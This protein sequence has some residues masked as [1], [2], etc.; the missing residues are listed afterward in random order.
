MNDREL[1]ELVHAERDALADDLAGLDDA[2]WRTP[3]LCGDWTV[4]ETLAHL[5]AVATLGTPAWLRSVVGVRWDFDRHN[6]L[7]MREQ[8]GAGP[9]ETLARFRA[10]AHARTRILGPRPAALGENVIHAAD[11]RRPLGLPSRTAPT[12]AAELLTWFAT[13]EFA[14]VSR[15]RVRGLEL[16]ATDAE[17]AVGAGARVEGPALALLLATC[18]RSDALADLD[19]DGVAVLTARCRPGWTARGRG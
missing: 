18:G 8:L 19:G 9:A 16:R 11:I 6:E 10:A 4:R 5:T 3:S 15:S 1:W 12:V 14:V 17:V 2:A 13:H 7:R